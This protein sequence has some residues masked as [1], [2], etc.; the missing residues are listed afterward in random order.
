MPVVDTLD[1]K[2]EAMGTA[3]RRY[4]FAE[5]TYKEEK[6]KPPRKEWELAFV[7][8]LQPF[9]KYTSFSGIVADFCD[10][11]ASSARAKSSNNTQGKHFD[12]VEARKVA[13]ALGEALE[14]LQSELE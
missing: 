10:L 7:A 13:E 9:K 11:P 2:K 4:K 8:G 5:V 12:K 6:E 3:R 14:M 1:N